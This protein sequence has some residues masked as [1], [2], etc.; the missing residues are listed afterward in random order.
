M[1]KVMNF[2]SF[3]ATIRFI[4]GLLPPQII[5]GDETQLGIMQTRMDNEQ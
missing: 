1:T 2:N 5:N 3:T 4:T